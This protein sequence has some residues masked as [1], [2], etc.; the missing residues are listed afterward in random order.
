M[1]HIFTSLSLLSTLLLASHQSETALISKA[2]AAQANTNQACALWPQVANVA[3]IAEIEAFLTECTEGFYHGMALSRLS[4]LK[5]ETRHTKAPAK[6]DVDHTPASNEPA[7]DLYRRAKN[8]QWGDG[9][10]PKDYEKALDLFKQAAA[11]GHKKSMTDIGWMNENGFGTP[12]NIKRAFEWYKKAADLGES[13]AL[14]NLGWMYTQGKAT[15]IDY[16]KAVRLYRR[17]VALGE[18]L[19]MT[20]LGWMYETGKGVKQDNKQA[21]SYYQRAADAG[22]LQGLHNTGWMHAAGLGTKPNPQKGA[23]AVYKALRKG[24]KF[25]RDQMT[26]NYDIWPKEFRREMQ[27]IL[28][29]DGY[30]NGKIDG[31]FGASTIAA[32]ERASK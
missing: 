11:K 10:L 1:R 23:T 2:N 7:E 29:R 16:N 12:K 20:N 18:P 13:M 4:E 19:A 25:S 27:K 14:N 26:T 6:P 24:N 32:V 28:K 21:F 31:N 17:S 5:G 9:G 30:Y 3:S 22:D 15:K 8:Y